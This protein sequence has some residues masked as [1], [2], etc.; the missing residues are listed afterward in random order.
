MVGCTQGVHIG[1]CA[2]VGVACQ[3]VQGHEVGGAFDLDAYPGVVVGVD[4]AAGEVGVEELQSRLLAEICVC[5][6]CGWWWRW[7]WSLWVQLAVAGPMIEW[8]GMWVCWLPVW[9]RREDASRG[10]CVRCVCLMAAVAALVAGVVDSVAA[11]Y[12]SAGHQLI[13]CD[14]GGLLDQ[15]GRES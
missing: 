3:G 6:C 1:I 2:E 12:R 13:L 8:V 4:A 7:R 10:W 14:G 5:E 9:D 15:T 11:A